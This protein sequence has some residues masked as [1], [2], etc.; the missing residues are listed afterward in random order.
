MRST[1]NLG[2]VLLAMQ[3]SRVHLALVVDRDGHTDGLVSLEDV[4]ESLVGQI[5]DETD[6]APGD[7]AAS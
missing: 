5:A 2:D 3:R 7:G 6:K 1:R 4:L